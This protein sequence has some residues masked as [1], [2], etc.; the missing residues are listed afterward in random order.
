[1]QQKILNRENRTIVYDY[2]ARQSAPCVVYLHGLNSSRK[3]QKGERLKAF[4]LQHGFAYL[5]V[6]YTAHGESEGKPSD[7]RI[8]RCF[9][10]VLDV[11]A[12]ENITNPLYLAGSSLGGWIAFLLAVERPLQIKGVLTLAAGVD[13]LPFVWENML[14]APVKALLKGG[15]IIGPS[16]ETRGYCF[17]YAMFKEAEPY[18]LLKKPIAYNGPVVLAHGD[19]DTVILPENSFK[20][21]DALESSDVAVHIIKGEGHRLESYP[22][23]E[24]LLKLIAKGEKNATEA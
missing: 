9:N 19:K 6:D 18:L 17:S 23:E 15:M 11:I 21:K 12:A 2:I 13:F 4:A 3:S 5:S 14:P 24:T 7:F 16:E 20:I 22:M 8:A 1:M 10:D